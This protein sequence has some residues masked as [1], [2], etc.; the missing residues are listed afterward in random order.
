MAEQWLNRFKRSEF[1]GT[2]NNASYKGI[3][4]IIIGDEATF[5][6]RTA[7]HEFPGRDKPKVEDLGRKAHLKTIE[8]RVLGGDYLEQRDSLVAACESEGAGTLIHPYYGNLDVI[9]E[10]ITPRNSSRET[11]TAVFQLS[12]VETG[13]AELLIT[14]RDTES[15][16]ENGAIE[17]ANSAKN[18]FVSAYNL[19]KKIAVY[20]D[21]KLTTV[22]TAFDDI[23]KAKK[24]ADVGPEFDR[25][26]RIYK[27]RINA[28]IQ[29]PGDLFD[30]LYDLMSFDLLGDDNLDPRK[31]FEGFKD[32]LD[33]APVVRASSDDSD[34]ISILLQ[35]INSILMGLL[36]SRIDFESQ[37]EAREFQNLVFDKWDDLR[38]AGSLDDEVSQNLRDLRDSILDDYDARS[39]D[40]SNLTTKEPVVTLP[41]LVLSYNLYGSVDQEDDIIKRNKIYHP[42]F[43]QG[44]E[45]VEVLLN[46]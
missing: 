21:G 46:A 45:P 28:I 3:P 4:F 13:E 34:A 27:A 16:V 38:E 10:T 19:V 20:L 32:N 15:A 24:R 42:A 12:F 23:E 1:D 26:L 22:E 29:A 11:R 31:S 39:F 37:D 35:L 5:G 33:F 9:C 36:L 43:V 6:R 41:A 25:Q 18:P 17:S 40:I 2:P 30:S 14:Q 8:G 44:G 7:I